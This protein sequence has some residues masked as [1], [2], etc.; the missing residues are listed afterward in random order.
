MLLVLL[1][2]ILVLLVT[3]V[4]VVLMML[5]VMRR[6]RVDG[7]E[8]HRVEVM[9]AG[10]ASPLMTHHRRGTRGSDGLLVGWR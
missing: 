10:T 8:R 4:L 9:K 7:V 1:L 2:L 5:L 6:Q 3:D